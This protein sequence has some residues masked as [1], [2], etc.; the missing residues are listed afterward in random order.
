MK[1]SDSKPGRSDPPPLIIGSGSVGGK[2]G[3]LIRLHD[4]LRGRFQ[5]EILDFTTGIP[6]LAVLTTDHFDRFLQENRLDSLRESSLS[7]RVISHHFLESDLSVKIT[8][9]LREMIRHRRSPLAIRSSSYL[10]DQLEAPYAGIYFTKMIPNNHPDPDTRFR[11]LRDAIKLVYASTF[12]SRARA[13][14]RARGI[15]HHREKMAIIIQEVAGRESNRRFYPDISGVARSFSY[16]NFG[17]SRPEHG[18]VNLALGLGKTIVDG[19]IS[20]TYNPR[21]PEKI[22]P[23]NSLT[24]RLKNTQTRFWAID[25]GQVHRFNPLNETEFLTRLELSDAEYDNRLTHIA[26]TY[27]AQSDTILPGIG[28]PGPRM[29]DF[30]PV[31]QYRTLPLNNT[32]RKVL[33]FC[34]ETVE[35]QVEI[36][37]AVTFQP[38]RDHPHHFSLLQV[39]PMHTYDPSQSITRGNLHEK[40]L[41][42]KSNQVMGNGE[43]SG[44]D[45]VVYLKSPD[46]NPRNAGE[47]VSEIDQINHRLAES[48]RYY[49]LIGTGRWGSSDPCLGIPVAWPQISNARIIIELKDPRS[50]IDYSQGSHF[51]HNLCNLGIFYFHVTQTP[52]YT[53]DWDWLKK[54][55][56]V[57][58]GRHVRAVKCRQALKVYVDGRHNQGE[59]YR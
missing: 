51:F 56:K 2:A 49:L 48:D 44:I 23:F 27:N 53:L 17:D 57:Y 30:G 25:T 15:D 20:W 12:F 21:F 13:Y 10:E 55:E 46:L 36:E 26:S 8:G 37:F 1:E 29:I 32:I 31:L 43:M 39:R 58:N 18:V 3:G 16:Y 5:G 38:R 24:D 34:R 14:S 22:P 4:Q 52:P 41:L 54:Q 19:G 40:D 33:D 47:I 50:P 7:D 59:I 28:R 6:S 11:A 42:V 9:V 45:H 35:S